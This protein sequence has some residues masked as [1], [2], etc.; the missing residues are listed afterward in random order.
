MTDLMKCL[1]CDR[2]IEDDAPA[3]VVICGSCADDLRQEEQAMMD[4]LEAEG[5][6]DQMNREAYEDSLRQRQGESE[7]RYI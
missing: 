1:R 6:A 2:D 7:Y 3:N 4:T 5:I